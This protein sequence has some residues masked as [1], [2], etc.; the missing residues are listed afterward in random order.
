MFKNK[1]N[2]IL[3]VLCFGNI[4]STNINQDSNKKRKRKDNSLENKS[5]KKQKAYNVY[6]D[7]QI[8]ETIKKYVQFK[9]TFLQDSYFTNDDQIWLYQAIKEN[10]KNKVNEIVLNYN[11]NMNP[12]IL[13]LYNNDIQATELFISFMN[14][15][16]LDNYFWNQTVETILLNAIQSNRIDIIKILIKLKVEVD[17]LLPNGYTALM[18]AVR[19]GNLDLIK[20]LV[21][22]GADVTEVDFDTNDNA[23]LLAC[24]NNHIET[25]KLLIEEGADLNFSD[26]AYKSPLV[27]ACEN[28]NLELVNILLK[29]GASLELD[30]ELSPCFLPLNAAA[31]TGNLEIVKVLIKHGAN[32][33]ETDGDKNTALMYAATNNHINIVKLLLTNGAEILLKNNDDQSVLNLTTNSM[34]KNLIFI[35]MFL[36]IIDLTKDSNRINQEVISMEKELKKML[37]QRWLKLE[38]LELLKH[39]SS[40]DNTVAEILKFLK[41]EVNYQYKICINQIL[42]K[43]IK[44]DKFSDI[45]IKTIQ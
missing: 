6:S 1:I 25:V 38:K 10:N 18:N 44:S 27:I 15:N 9:S 33:N 3:L 42:P 35:V 37:I 28:Q 8:K 26:G 30:E 43:I 24:K 19:I 39:F 34:I 36:E 41:K 23:L 11:I 16:K 20:I 40:Y 2:L 31:G 17:A 13:A 5:V 45:I 14:L 4:F 12:I 7:S 21:S 22:S 29:S 32:I